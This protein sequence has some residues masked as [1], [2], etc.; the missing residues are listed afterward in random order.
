MKRLICTNCDDA[1]HVPFCY[2]C[3]TSDYIGIIE[4]DSKNEDIEYVMSNFKGSYTTVHWSIMF[5]VPAIVAESQMSKFEVLNMLQ[6]TDFVINQIDHVVNAQ[7]IVVPVI[8]V[9]FTNV[10]IED[11]DDMEDI[12]YSAYIEV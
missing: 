11:D 2:G 9:S 8:G 10:E 3:S 7:N 1:L 6:T 4:A 5:E 12:A